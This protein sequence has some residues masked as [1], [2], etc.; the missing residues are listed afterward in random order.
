[1]CFVFFYFTLTLSYNMRN[2]K[3]DF[4]NKLTNFHLN[5]LCTTC[6]S[7]IFAYSTVFLYNF[8][9]QNN[10]WWFLFQRCTDNKRRLFI[11]IIKKQHRIRYAWHFVIRRIVLFEQIF[12]P[13]NGVDTQAEREHS[14]IIFCF[15][16]FY[17]LNL[18]HA[19]DCLCN[20]FKFDFWLWG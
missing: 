18:F 2:K 17:C 10:I 5:L 19:C 13:Q 15:E 20:R 3:P 12:A 7:T 16:S 9:G 11:G 6:K 4:S 8:Y 1:M 14:K